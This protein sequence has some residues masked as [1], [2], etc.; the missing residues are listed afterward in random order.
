MPGVE[1][2]T[3]F[4]AVLSDLAARYLAIER[5]EADR[6]SDVNML[7]YWNWLSEEL[8]EQRRRG[9]NPYID[10]ISGS[11]AFEFRANKLARD[12]DLENQE[13]G[14]KLLA[15][16]SLLTTIDLLHDRQYEAL[17]GVAC[18]QLGAT[19][20]RLTPKG[21]EGGIDFLA[22]IK[23][24]T[25]SHIFSNSGA[26]LRIVGQCKKYESALT[27]PKMDGII[28]TINN[29]RHRAPRI[30]AQIPVW[31]DQ[32]HGPIVGWVIAHKGY[33]SGAADDAKQHG[34]ITSDTADIAELLSLSNDFYPTTPSSV[35]GSE[36]SDDCD[37]IIAG[38]GI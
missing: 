1:G 12:A 15:R 3:S 33:Q 35:R 37:L 34:I 16:P 2:P 36:L 10:L 28:Q 9:I 32:A 11:Y 18:N 6:F 25:P 31:F 5:A 24:R 26:A 14:K 17:A 7:R 23:V 19:N 22:T 38:S 4:R 13:L 27:A 29:V 30:L 21:S 8:D 20:F